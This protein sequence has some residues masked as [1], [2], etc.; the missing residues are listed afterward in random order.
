MIWLLFGCRAPILLE[1]SAPLLN[2]G[3]VEFAALYEGPGLLDEGWCTGPGPGLVWLEVG[4][5]DLWPRWIEPDELVE[6]WVHA[7]EG[8][9]D[10]VYNCE[11]T[12]PRR[13]DGFSV[14][15]VVL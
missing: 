7:T 10:G 6:V 15:V 2:P 11:I 9:G 14:E 3:E 13:V 12:V 5:G 8:A 4:P 1:M